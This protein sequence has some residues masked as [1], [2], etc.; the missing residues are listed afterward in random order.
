MAQQVVINHTGTDIKRIEYLPLKADGTREA[1]IKHFVLGSTLDGIDATRGM[2]GA[3]PCRFAMDRAD[4]DAACKASKA[5]KG[6]VDM[7]V[8][9]VG[10]VLS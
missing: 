9:Q 2:V 10:G 6:Y 5:F 7:G 8:V 1:K 3:P 4:F